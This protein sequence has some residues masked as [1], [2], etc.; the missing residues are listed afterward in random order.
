MKQLAYEHFNSQNNVE[1]Y[2]K[3]YKD[4]DFSKSYPADVKRL[5][6]FQMLLNKYRPKNIIDAGCGAG[7]PLVQIK[8]MGFN[9]YGYDKSH[10]MV[11]E[12][13]KNLKANNLS[14]NLI[15]IDDF[16]NPK[17]IKDDSVDCILGMG[18]FY[19]SKKFILTLK[20][21]RNKLKSNGRLIFSLRNQLFDI[22]TLN[23]YSIK[24]YSNLYEINKFKPPIKK[25]YL[26]LFQGYSNREKYNLKNLDDKKVYSITHNPLTIENEILSKAGLKCDGIYFYHFHALPPVFENIDTINFRKQSFKIENPNDWRGLFIASCF[27]VDCQKI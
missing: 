25:E 10:N 17:H 22:A 11:K 12:A 5:E 24:F 19:Y 4:I 23:D 27:V 2:S 8:K 26:E 18:V 14:S 15:S 6:I 21:Q 20:N 7:M 3:M 9:I 16:E 13:K 1:E